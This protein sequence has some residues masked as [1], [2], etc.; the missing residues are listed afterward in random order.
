MSDERSLCRRLG[1]PALMMA[2]L[3]VLAG[4]V[5]AQGQPPCVIVDSGPGGRSYM[6]CG[7]YENV[8]GNA[9]EPTPAFLG[10]RYGVQASTRWKPAIPY[11]GVGIQ[12]ATQYGPICP[13]RKSTCKAQDHCDGS[14]PNPA[15]MSEDC[16][17]MN[18]WTPPNISNTKNLPVMVFIHGGD[19]IEGGS[20]LP[21]SNCQGNLFDGA[22]LA[23]TYNQVVVTFNYRLGAL[24]F[25]ASTTKDASGNHLAAGNFGLMDQQLAIKWVIE[26]ISAFG[27]NP[28]NITLVGESAGAYSVGMHV[29]EATQVPNIQA[30]VMESNPLAIPLKN[31][32]QAENYFHELL[33]A[34]GCTGILPDWKAC[35]AKAQKR[36]RRHSVTS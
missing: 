5:H 29:L 9:A 22:Y 13:Q 12:W 1:V 8:H 28:N 30:G 23:N 32:T 21:D 31:R 16:L 36:R 6:I 18:I 27:G 33:R 34:L 7:T 14:G 19:F 11:Y 2:G 10:I 20:D 25:L 4:R 26:N 15:Y 3:L 35:F 24:G 17:F